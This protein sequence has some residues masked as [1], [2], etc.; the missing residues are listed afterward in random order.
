MKSNNISSLK[1]YIN[2][3][4]KHLSKP[5]FPHSRDRNNSAYTTLN[6]NRKVRNYSYYSNARS[7]KQTI[8]EKSLT[9][10]KQGEEF[11]QDAKIDLESNNTKRLEPMSDYLDYG[12]LTGKIRPN[13][14]KFN[15]TSYEGKVDFRIKSK[16]CKLEEEIN[17]LNKKN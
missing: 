13:N 17:D 6:N 8:D 4:K 7:K 15:R 5:F 10:S 3:S 12:F 9:K 2:A 1:E 11:N 14:Q 16:K